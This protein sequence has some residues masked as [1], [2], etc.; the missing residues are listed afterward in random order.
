MHH[1]T[2]IKVTH[3]VAACVV[4]SALLTLSLIPLWIAPVFVFIHNL[5]H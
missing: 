1:L 5:L 2:R 3:L 4:L